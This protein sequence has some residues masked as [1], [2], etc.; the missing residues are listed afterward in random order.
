MIMREQM[1]KNKIS[2]VIARHFFNDLMI[3]QI[4]LFNFNY[5][6]S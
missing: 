6:F 2:Q 4:T 3:V 1:V 5:I